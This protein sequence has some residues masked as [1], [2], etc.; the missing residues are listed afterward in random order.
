M[1]RSIRP[2]PAT[3]KT[4]VPESVIWQT[5]STLMDATVPDGQYG[6]HRM[7]RGLLLTQPPGSLLLLFHCRRD[8]RFLA[9]LN[10]PRNHLVFVE[11]IHSGQLNAAGGL[12]HAE[13]CHGR[14]WLKFVPSDE[15]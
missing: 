9:G 15:H 12:A 13:R 4:S 10:H 2:K 14:F 6:F 8:V 7:K 5:S 3:N 11:L 1:S